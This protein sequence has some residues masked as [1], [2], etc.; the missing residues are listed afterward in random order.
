MNNTQER[1]KFVEA[2]HDTSLFGDG[3]VMSLSQENCLEMNYFEILD[4]S[5]LSGSM[6]LDDLEL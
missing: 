5:P 1:E 2:T 4:T 3:M 6:D